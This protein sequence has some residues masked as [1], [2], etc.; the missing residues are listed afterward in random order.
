M[1]KIKEYLNWQ[2]LLIVLVNLF[3]VCFYRLGI[4][5]LGIAAIKIYFSHG[6]YSSAYE[7]ALLFFSLLFCLTRVLYL[8]ILYSCLDKKS[9]NK[10]VKNFIYNL[11]NNKKFRI[12]ILCLVELPTLIF[13]FNGISYNYFGQAVYEFIFFITLS[14]VLLD[15]FGSYVFLFLWWKV[16]GQLK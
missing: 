2:I 6:T 5:I 15:L 10:I 12:I 4:L 1:A 13:A 8:P 16:T 11:K 7:Y 9:N 3:L 14:F